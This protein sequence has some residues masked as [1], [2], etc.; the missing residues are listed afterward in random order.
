ML[1]FL[2]FWIHKSKIGGCIICTCY[3]MSSVA[4]TTAQL[5]HEVKREEGK[6]ESGIPVS[7]SAAPKITH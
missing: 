5:S 7:L 4:E 2:Q 1:F 3:W 6:A